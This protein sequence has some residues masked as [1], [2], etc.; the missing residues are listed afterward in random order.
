MELTLEI[1]ETLDT[2][3]VKVTGD[4]DLYTSTQVRAAIIKA[5]GKAPKAVAVDLRGVV[6]MD[7]SGVATLIEGLRAAAPGKVAF[8]LAAPSRP[9]M[10]VLGLARL[11]SVFDIREGG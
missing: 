10:K 3:T 1:V 8:S 6:Y 5:I 9:V 7:S 2:I 11:E 4:V